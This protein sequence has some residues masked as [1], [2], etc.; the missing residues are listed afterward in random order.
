MTV[1]P[2]AAARLDSARKQERAKA[3]IAGYSPQ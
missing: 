3:E 1:D 2:A